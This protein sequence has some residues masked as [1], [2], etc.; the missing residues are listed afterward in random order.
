MLGL[1]RESDIW[2]REQWGTGLEGQVQKSGVCL[3]LVGDT[4]IPERKAKYGAV[5]VWDRAE[6]FSSSSIR[7]VLM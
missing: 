5:K 1:R 2:G 6:P 7:P 4:A 3:S